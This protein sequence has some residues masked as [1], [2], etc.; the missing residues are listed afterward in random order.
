VAD[1]RI[2]LVLVDDVPDVRFVVG[3][4]LELSGRFEALPE[5]RAASP[6]GWRS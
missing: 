3:R 4:A 6:G 1:E 2:D 5:V